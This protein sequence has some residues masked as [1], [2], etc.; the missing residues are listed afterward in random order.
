MLLFIIG[1]NSYCQQANS[2]SE[3]SDTEFVTNENLSIIKLR[4]KKGKKFHNRILL[5]SK[6]LPIIVSIA[7]LQYALTSVL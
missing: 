3:E 2:I 1:N 6:R 5:L 7:R 4:Y